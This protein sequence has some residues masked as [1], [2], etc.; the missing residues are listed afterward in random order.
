MTS[1]NGRGLTTRR[2]VVCGGASRVDDVTSR[3][4]RRDR[5]WGEEPGGNRDR[6]GS[7]VTDGEK[8]AGMGESDVSPSLGL[9]LALAG[10]WLALRG[11][12]LRRWPRLLALLD[13]IGRGAPR[14]LHP[15]HRHRL[16]LGLR[17]AV[18]SGMFEGLPAPPL[19]D[20]LDWL[21]PEG[22]GAGPEQGHA[23]SSPR[24]RPLLA[25]AEQNFRDQVLGMLGKG[26]GHGR[27]LQGYGEPFLGSLESLFFEF[28]LRV[29]SALPPP[30]LGQLER[31]AWG[32][33]PSWLRPRA[34]PA[35]RR[36]LADVGHA[37]RGGVPRPLPVARSTPKRMKPRPRRRKLRPLLFSPLGKPLPQ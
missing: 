8:G 12:S 30:D 36:Y 1:L 32:H 9:R 10:A 37:H 26:R 29:E 14:A 13:L 20:A 15:R 5:F 33:A 19:L 34:L 35:L 3:R 6:G 24:E 25:Q 16:S 17:A 28:V 18:I 11:R 27:E 7:D 23:H 2:G 22:E 4:E 21:F 31:L